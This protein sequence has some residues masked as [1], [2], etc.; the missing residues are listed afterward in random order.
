MKVIC[1]SLLL[2]G[3]DGGNLPQN[4]DEASHCKG[5]T[6]TFL[7]SFFLKGRGAGH[8]GGDGYCSNYLITFNSTAS[9]NAGLVSVRWHFKVNST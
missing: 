9:V 1:Q 4:A 5:H 6:T 3:R 2:N 8:K 7:T